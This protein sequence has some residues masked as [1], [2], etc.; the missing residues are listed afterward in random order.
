MTI[1]LGEN[2]LSNL[3]VG[4]FQNLPEVFFLS[5]D[6]NQLTSLPNGI[7]DNVYGA[8]YALMLNNNQLTTLPNG[9]FDNLRGFAYL[10]L[11]DNQL[12]S[13]PIG[14]FD[15]IDELHLLDLSNNRL[16]SLPSNIFDTVENN[17]NSANI[18]LDYNCIDT[19]INF[20]SP[21]MLTNGDRKTEQRVCPIISYA[22]P[23]PTL[24]P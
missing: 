20:S 16:T 17:G 15:T 11:N 1:D 6:N 14:M 10:T 7:F 3:P 13:L 12:T 2:E 23:A 21:P 5:L 9:I 18:N 19:S 24:T 4:I 22:P 8:W